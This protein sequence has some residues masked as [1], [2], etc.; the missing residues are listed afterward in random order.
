[1][2]WDGSLRNR[3]YRDLVRAMARLTRQNKPIVTRD[4]EF[5]LKR[6]KQLLHV[7]LRR[8]EEEGFVCMEG[9]VQEMKHLSLTDAGRAVAHTMGA[10]ILGT[11]P[12]G[13]LRAVP[14][15]DG[16]GMEG[17]LLFRETWDDELPLTEDFATL[18]VTGDSMIGD[19]IAPGDEVQLERG[20]KLHELEAGEIAAVL[21][22]DDYEA[23]LKHVYL[24]PDAGTVTLRA[25][26]PIYDDIVVLA[27]EVRVVGAYYGMVRVSPTRNRKP[28]K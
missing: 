9:G 10:P 22:G 23:T 26:N 15:T 20:V 28:R 19:C 13:S 7:Q 14:E 25:S 5:D 18:V 3:S 4:L 21:V 6:S 8:L 17:E 12:A 27:N 2:E 24:N 16:H 1:M 11:V